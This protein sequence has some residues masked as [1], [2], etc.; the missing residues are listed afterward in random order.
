MSWSSAQASKVG[1]KGWRNSVESRQRL[2]NQTRAVYAASPKLCKYCN[3][4]LSFEKQ[5]YTFCSQ[6]HAAAFNNRGKCRNGKPHYCLAC[7]KKVRNK[8]C[9]PKCKQVYDFREK[10]KAG[11]LMDRSGVRNYL[12]NTRPH[13]CETCGY[14]EW[15]GQK[16]PL[17][18]HHKD[19]NSDNNNDDNLELKCPNCHAQTD[20][21]KNKN[22]GNGRTT[23]LRQ[24]KA[25]REA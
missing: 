12:L 24:A 6:S 25:L 1:K 17:E 8:F 13:R 14:G 22:R 4:P 15:L 2:Y 16:I 9:G 5:K 10:I 23:R 7:Q 11:I 19:G 20:T 21:F 18:A 3:H